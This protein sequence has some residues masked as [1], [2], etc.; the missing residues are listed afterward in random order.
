VVAV[1]TIGQ[2]PRP[3][4]TIDLENRFGRVP[5]EIVGALDDH[6]VDT[7]SCEPEGYPLETRLRDGTRVVVDTAFVEPLLQRA[8]TG[9]D[10]RASVHLVSCAGLFTN[11]TALKTI[12]QPF[13][14]AV[15]ELAARGVESM[16]MVV[17]FAEQRG[18]ALGKWQ[19]AGFS[20]RAHVLGDGPAGLSVAK[21]LCDR[22]PD[23]GADAV[24]FDYVGFPATI[25]DELATEIDIPVFDLGH[26]ALDALEGK[27]QTL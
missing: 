20:C 5:F 26:L 27:L 13:E 18:P 25:L 10:E 19:A 15:A 4:L 14:V 9:M 1:Y 12:I 7:L 22:I 17:P 23:T 24:V 21:W 11:L 6:S 16:E 3:D 2:T 8:I